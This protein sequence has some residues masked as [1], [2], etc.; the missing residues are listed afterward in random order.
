MPKCSFCDYDISKGRGIMVVQPNGRVFNFCS[1]K[2]EVNMLK[3]KRDP[4]KV[5]WTRK[6]KKTASAVK[7]DSKDAEKPTEK[8]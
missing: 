2:C 6:K 8:K 7:T 1:H 3:L 4:R 5:G